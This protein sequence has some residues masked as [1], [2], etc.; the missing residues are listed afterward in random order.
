MI[1]IAPRETWKVLSYDDA[2]LYAFS[3]SLDGKI[4]W[5]LP[6]S[7]ENIGQREYWCFESQG[8]N[9]IPAM[10]TGPTPPSNPMVGDFWISDNT[11]QCLF[12]T[13]NRWAQVNNVTHEMPTHQLTIL[14]RELK[15]D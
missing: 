10:S 12:Y 7:H 1:E 5:R 2:K 6:H 14:V 13:G 3:F 15:D 9:T 8:P 11:G 4:G